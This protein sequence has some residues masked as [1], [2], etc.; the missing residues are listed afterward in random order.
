M[1]KGSIMQGV[2]YNNLTVNLFRDKLQG[3]KL[4]EAAKICKVVYGNAWLQL[5]T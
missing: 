5:A 2:E 4:E 1:D 3:L